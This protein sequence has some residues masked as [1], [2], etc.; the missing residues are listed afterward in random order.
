M[1]K[2]FFFRRYKK[3]GWNPHKFQL[4]RSIR[5]NNLK[6]DKNKLLKRLRSKGIKLKKI[7]FLKD[8]YW[9]Y[10]SDFSIGATIEYLLGLYSI[11]E[12]ASQIPVTIFD[13]PIE[14]TILDAC[15]APGGKTVQLAV[16]MKNTGIIIGLDVNNRRLIALFNQL[17]RC[18]I[19]N[20]IICKMDA[21]KV[22][23]LK[24]KFDGALLDVPCSGN[25]I[26]DQNWFENKT[27]RDVK[28]IA[29]L[30]RRILKESYNVVKEGGEIVY[31]TCS[32]EPEE[33]ELNIDWA[34]QNLN[35]KIEEIDCYGEKGL[36]SIFGKDLDS[37]LEN[38]KR[39]WPGATQGFFICKLR[40]GA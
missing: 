11:Q 27:I 22:E 15:A 16:R 18:K 34:I 31:S 5:I 32:L 26:A 38:C 19:E 23:R 25:F 4:R 13:N 33:N 10:K 17:E 35:L 29:R 30:Q 1:S 20:S 3:L 2:R 40:K 39:I 12:A 36:T 6:I 14:K 8:G 37:S 28:N 7:P 21:R 24:M 9:I